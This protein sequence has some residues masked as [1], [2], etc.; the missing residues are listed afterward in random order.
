LTPSPT[1][2][3]LVFDNSG[4]HRYEIYSGEELAGLAVYTSTA[5]RLV[6]THVETRPPFESHG[7]GSRLV[8]AALDDARRQNKRV[9]ARCPFVA[10]YIRRH[11]EYGD[12]VDGTRAA[13]VE[14]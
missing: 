9:I 8:R 14:E 4:E 11:P 12:L 3:P 7:F 10:S 2:D 13:E 5:D 6:F 1:G